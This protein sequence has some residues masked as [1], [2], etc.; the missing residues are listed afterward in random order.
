MRKDEE[1][2]VDMR[3][4]GTLTRSS[5]A[6]SSHFAIEAYDKRGKRRA[7]WERVLAAVTRYPG[8]SSK[9]L[10]SITGMDRHMIARRLPDIEYDG[11]A[12]SDGT[13]TDGGKAWYPGSK[14]SAGEQLGLF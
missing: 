6:P 13:A 9:Q 5:D 14:G 12:H 10:A 11:K 2:K 1:G 4:T 8:H 3:E 7:N